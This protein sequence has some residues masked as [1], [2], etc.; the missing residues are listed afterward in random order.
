MEKHEVNGNTDLL[1]QRATTAV[2]PRRLQDYWAT[3]GQWRLNSETLATLDH[4]RLK[5]LGAWNINLFLCLFVSFFSWQ[6]TLAPSICRTAYPTDVLVKISNT[7]K[8]YTLYIASMQQ[9][10]GVSHGFPIHNRRV[11]LPSFSKNPG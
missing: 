11:S 5:P 6:P 2:I 7:K 1:N 9:S 8:N 3:L 4:L 10:D